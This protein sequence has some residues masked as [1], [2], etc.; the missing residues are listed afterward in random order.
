VFGF[1]NGRRRDEIDW[2]SAESQQ[3]RSVSIFLHEPTELLEL[4]PGWI[5]LDDYLATSSGATDAVVFKGTVTVT[6]MSPSNARSR[7][8]KASSP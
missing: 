8:S 7:S 1:W 6:R 3:G 5:G 2:W 4:L